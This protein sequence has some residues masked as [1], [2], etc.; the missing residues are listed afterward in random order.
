MKR[1]DW[2]KDPCGCP[3]CRQAGVGDVPQQ[4]DPQT[5]CWLHGY[6]LR[7]VRDAADQV[8]QQI[9]DLANTKAMR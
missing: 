5:G 1:E 7:R 6:A 3:E 8:L 2:Q 9:K 4:R